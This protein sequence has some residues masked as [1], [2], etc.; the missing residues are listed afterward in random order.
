MARNVWKLIG[1]LIVVALVL[2]APAQ[3]AFPGRNGKL[4]FQRTNAYQQQ[5]GLY[6]VD[7]FGI[8][9][10][11]VTN[12]QSTIL[13]TWSPDGQRIAFVDSAAIWTMKPD[14]SDRTLVL[15]WR[16]SVWTLSWSPDGA[17][18]VAELWDCE[19]QCTQD[20][21]TMNLDGTGLTNITAADGMEDRHPAWSPDGTKIAFS[22]FVNGAAGLYTMNP[23]GSG[24]SPLE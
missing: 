20:I 23:D 12:S 7:P 22:G 6:A 14:G 21:Y 13:P 17:K 10:D 18:L 8:Q 16:S 3:A 4:M 9:E 19:F 5:S 1:G 24:K 15:D 11:R 2:S